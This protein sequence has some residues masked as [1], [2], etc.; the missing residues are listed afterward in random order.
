MSACWFIPKSRPPTVTLV[1]VHPMVLETFR[2]L[3]TRFVETFLQYP[4]GYSARL[5]VVCNGEKAKPS[6]KQLFTP[7]TPVI[8]PEFSYHNNEAHDVGAYQF[9]ARNFLDCDLMVFFGAST[10][11]R[12]K[13][14]LLR[15]VD[16]WEKHGDGLFG[17]M[18]NKGNSLGPRPHLRTTA[19]W[20]SPHIF[21]AYPYRIT[22][23]DRRYEFEHGATNLTGWVA[24]E[25]LPTLVVSWIGEHPFEEWDTHE[26]YHQ[27]DQKNLLCGDRMS[28]PPY[29]HCS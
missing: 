3:A 10:Y 7:L 18:G 1:Y 12:R 14:W 23:A 2:D 11:F 9:A 16:S 4:P 17:A 19:F 6:T 24:H 22:R 15:M 21:N 8:T 5:I 13:G 25:G 28:A 27:G 29:H 20:T 26:G